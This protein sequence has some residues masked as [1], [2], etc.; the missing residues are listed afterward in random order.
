VYHGVPEL[1][2]TVWGDQLYNAARMQYRG[3][4]LNVGPMRDVTADKLV[5]SARDVITNS[6][7]SA[8][9]RAASVIFRSR[10]QNPRQRAAWWIDHVIQHGGGHL[11]SYALD[12]PWYEYLMLDLLLVVMVIPLVLL[13]SAVTACCMLCC[14]LVRR[15]KVPSVTSHHKQQ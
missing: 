11:H 4:G 12:M 14:C 15:H 5:A 13:T 7:Y 1:C 8:A 2:L 3:Y 10:P 6:S 9:A